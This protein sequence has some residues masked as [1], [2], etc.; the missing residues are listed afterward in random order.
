MKFFSAQIEQQQTD[1]KKFLK[2]AGCLSN[3]FS[4]SSVPYLYYRVA[5]KIF[6]KSFQ[7]EDLSRSDVSA[8]AKKDNMGIGLKTFL[9]GNSKTYQKVAEFNA[10]RN[11]YGSLNAPDLVRK[12]AELRNAR[13][14]FTERAYRL[15]Q[16]LYHCVL[17][18]K[19]KFL[20]FEEPM[21]R[22]EIGNIGNI[23]KNSGSISFQDGKNDYSFL[24]SKSTLTKRFVTGSTVD[25][26]AIEVLE[27]P[28]AELERLLGTRNLEFESEARI[29]QSL[30]LPL[31]G[32]NKTVFERS[33]LNQWNARGRQRDSGEVYIPVPVEIHRNFPDFFP[34]RDTPFMLRLPD[35]RLMQSKICQ[36]G[37]KALMSSSNR[38]LGQ[39]ILRDVLGLAEGELL[40][41]E[42]LQTIGIDSVRVDKIS[43]NLFEINFS[44]IGSY[45]I[46]KEKF[47]S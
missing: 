6:C 46:F 31:Y 41:Y 9:A 36:D 35:G 29:K 10:D 15:D 4:E 7:A 8:D 2:I 18:D 38:K 37:G 43:D 22:I 17:R 27:D 3:L 42:K 39:W 11:S 20:I 26:L 40:T 34:N 47:N 14:D 19:G 24:F 12:I 45:E 44:A 33:G 23:K 25:E 16:M 30:F 1:Y 5:E 32:R 28:L 21:D 13:I